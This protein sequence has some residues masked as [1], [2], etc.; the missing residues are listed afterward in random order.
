[1]I[2]R[3]LL[4]VCAAGGLRHL[5]VGVVWVVAD[6]A[7]EIRIGAEPVR[8]VGSKVKENKGKKASEGLEGDS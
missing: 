4:H 6:I 1:M 7:L 3:V 8:E 5:P 2:S